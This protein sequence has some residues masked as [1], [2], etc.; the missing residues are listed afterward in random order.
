MRGSRDHG[1][2]VDEMVVTLMNRWRTKEGRKGHDPGVGHATDIHSGKRRIFATQVVLQGLVA[3]DY[4]W[5]V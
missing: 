4:R 3:C 1:R 5:L 2:G